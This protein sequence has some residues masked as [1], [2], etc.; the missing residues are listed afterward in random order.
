[1]AS[2]HGSIVYL[3]ERILFTEPSSER[4]RSDVTDGG[5][6]EKE[7]VLVQAKRRQDENYKNDAATFL[8]NCHLFSCVFES[9]VQYIFADGKGMKRPKSDIFKHHAFYRKGLATL[10]F[11]TRQVFHTCNQTDLTLEHGQC[12]RRIVHVIHK[13]IMQAR[14]NC[15][16]LDI[17]SNNLQQRMK[18]CIAVLIFVVYSSCVCPSIRVHDCRNI[19]IRLQRFTAY[20]TYVYPSPLVMTVRFSI[21]QLQDGPVLHVTSV[22]ANG[23][24]KPVSST[25]LSLSVSLAA[26]S[27]GPQLS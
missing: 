18:E 23:R 19:T 1:M 3:Y 4:G 20:L 25:A 5:M 27:L 21:P 15:P 12:R 7:E 16:S 17:S 9:I 2:K 6:Q 13:R 26:N 24:A 11:T 8:R 14:P 10:W 22:S